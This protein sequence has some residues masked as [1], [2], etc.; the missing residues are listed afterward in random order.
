MLLVILGAG[1]SH[2][3]INPKTVDLTSHI[4]PLSLRHFQPPLASGL[5][6]DRLNFG[7]VIDEFQEAA[8]L[9]AHLRRRIA[10][11]ASV[12]E[13]LERVQSD[14]QDGRSQQELVAVRFYLQ[15]TLWR[16]SEEWWKVA[17]GV[18]NYSELIRRLR[19]WHTNHPREPICLVTFNYD[20]LLEQALQ[21]V[22]G[23]ELANLSSY[24]V[25]DVKLFKLHGSV[26]WGHPLGWPAD[27]FTSWTMAAHHLIGQAS[28]IN[29]APN[30]PEDHFAVLKGLA[31]C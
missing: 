5:F 27:S 31:G 1:A 24:I 8:G 30:P 17:H 2:D 18:T 22:L 25:G 16:C 11:G 28:N 13:E 12:E 6:G 3:S 10:A 26:N 9:I 23:L 19:Q 21:H 20:T 15:W 14:A 7:E 4:P 29:R